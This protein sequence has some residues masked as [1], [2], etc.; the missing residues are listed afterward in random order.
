MRNVSWMTFLLFVFCFFVQ[1][2]SGAADDSD[3]CIFLLDCKNIPRTTPPP[4]PSP[5]APA[6][7]PDFRRGPDQNCVDSGGD[8]VVTNVLWGDSDNGLLLRAGAN[9]RAAVIA[10]IP[11]DA[12]G[13]EVSECDGGWCRVIYRCKAGWAGSKYLAAESAQYRRVVRVSPNDPEGLNL[14]AGPGS[15]YSKLASIPFNATGVIS[16]VCQTSGAD[17]VSWCLVTYRHTSG[18]AAARFLDF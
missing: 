9:S 12:V 11:P 17:G 1:S 3:G 10:V 16:H 4:P 7:A 13:V 8:H 18:W 15:T 14:R 6:P 2:S 5:P